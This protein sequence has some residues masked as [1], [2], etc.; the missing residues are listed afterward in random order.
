MA[1]AICG[2]LI[3]LAGVILGVVFS[4]A[5]FKMNEE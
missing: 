3:A 2:A 4:I 1:Y 5:I